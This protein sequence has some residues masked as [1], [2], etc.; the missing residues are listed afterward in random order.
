MLT[1]V[2]HAALLALLPGL[3]DDADPHQRGDH[4]ARNHGDDDDA[5]GDAAWPGRWGARASALTDRQLAVSPRG[6]Q[7]VGH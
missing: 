1:G 2:G 6:A 7:R 4:N 5:Y 3:V